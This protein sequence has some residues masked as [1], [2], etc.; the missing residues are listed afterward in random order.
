M[1]HI[2]AFIDLILYSNLWIAL[3]ALAMAAQTQF[4]LR[5][6]LEATPLLGFIFTATLLLYAVHR[7][8]G[9]NRA[10]PFKGSGRYFVIQRFKSHIFLYALIA[11]LGTLYCYIQMPL[12]L[13]LGVL[14]PSLLSIGYVV[15]LFGKQRRLRD[16][17]FV[18][19][20]LIAVAWSWITV[21]LPAS[22]L[23]MSG[24]FV[25][26]IMSIERALFI[27]AITIPFDIRDLEIDRYN[28]VKTLPLAWGVNRSKQMAYIALSM[29]V[30]LIALNVSM[31]AYSYSTAFALFISAA[32][33]GV[34]V[35]Y[36]GRFSN[37]YYYTGLVDGM[38]ASQSVLVY[39]LHFIL[40]WVG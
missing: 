31:S 24:N 38:M 3:A 26:I 8:F 5:G 15:P 18:K 20:F 16:F 14:A 32:L 12:R 19:I 4:L 21:L 30:C 7:M 37:D 9:L 35:Y 23:G 22:E 40:F 11:G 6:H 25:V 10:K 13:Q 39:S 1:R 2:N 33:S 17:N 34:L 29:F 28:G 27:F 36:S